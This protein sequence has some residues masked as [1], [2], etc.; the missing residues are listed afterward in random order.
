MDEVGRGM[1][2]A[3]AGLDSDGRGATAAKWGLGAGRVSGYPQGGERVSMMGSE[4]RCNVAVCTLFVDDGLI[5]DVL[6]PCREAVESTYQPSVIEMP[7]FD[8]ERARLL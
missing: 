3:G 2:A 8:K 4:D 5:L 7:G 6:R 1:S